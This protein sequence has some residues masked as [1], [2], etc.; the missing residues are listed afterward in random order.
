MDKIIYLA[1]KLKAFTF[2]EIFI[3]AEMEKE[4]LEDIL[5]KLV[6]ANVINKT[7]QGY[8]FVTPQMLRETQKK[9]I[10]SNKHY[11]IFVPHKVK[12][13]NMSFYTIVEH[14]FNNYVVKFCTKSTIKTYDSMFRN[15]I[16][17][18]FSDKKFV[19]IKI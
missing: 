1:S 13:K 19:K 17:P 7:T 3:L 6:I 5:K 8:V 9:K 18:Y 11:G 10:L 4:Q 16:L 15:H 12:N 2:D 14:F